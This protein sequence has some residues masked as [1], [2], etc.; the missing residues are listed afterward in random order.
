[1]KHKAHTLIIQQFV[2]HKFAHAACRGCGWTG[3]EGAPKPPVCPNDPNL[4]SAGELALL[5]TAMAPHAWALK[6][7]NGA[8]PLIGAFDSTLESLARDTMPFA[9]AVQ[10]AGFVPRAQVDRLLDV[11]LGRVKHTY[12]GLCPDGIEGWDTRDPECPACR[13]LA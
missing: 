1:M 7:G 2:G 9:V 5:N 4:D 6:M 12:N 13:V 11:A 8:S 3:R 10:D